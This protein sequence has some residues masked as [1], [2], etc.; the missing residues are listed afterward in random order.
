MN[1]FKT[2]IIFLLLQ[3]LN[4]VGQDI[5]I[6]VDK[7]NYTIVDKIKVTYKVGKNIDNIGELDQSQ[8]KIIKGPSQTSSQSYLN[9]K[10]IFEETYSYI[11][12]PRNTGKIELP[13]LEMYLD[14]QILKSE[15]LFVNITGTVLTDAEIDEKVKS[16]NSPYKKYMVGSVFKISLPAYLQKANDL[17]VKAPFCFRNSTSSIRGYAILETKED[18]ILS[19][20]KLNPILSF[21][22]NTVNE[23][24][25]DLKKKR[26][27]P[28]E[29]TKENDINFAQTD[30]TYF[31]EEINEDS[32]YFIGSVETK[33]ALYTIIINTSNQNKDKFKADF[34][35][36]LYSLKD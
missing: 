14:R 17:N 3:S 21:H 23:L 36:V 12:E 19:G 28:V 34:K 27:S 31:D 24:G 25:N 30:L 10:T 32:Y 22:E 18:V 1:F 11:L 13:Q 5:K 33:T 16:S 29:S 35:K 7:L 9:G 4:V 6:I 20:R 2:A 15:K 8:F 26:I